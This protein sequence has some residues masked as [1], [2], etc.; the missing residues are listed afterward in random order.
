MGE[1]KT[2]HLC[3][4]IV[5]LRSICPASLFSRSLL[6]VGAHVRAYTRFRM[7]LARFYS[8]TKVSAFV[9]ARITYHCLPVGKYYSNRMPRGVTIMFSFA[10]N[11]IARPHRFERVG[12]SKEL[13]ECE[14]RDE[15]DVWKFAV[16]DFVGRRKGLFVPFKRMNMKRNFISNARYKW[17]V[18]SEIV[19]PSIV[20]KKTIISYRLK[21]K[22]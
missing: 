21:K 18:S 6:V 17:L 1:P 8:T 7:T 3:I 4:V 11:P 9:P 12:A 20:V 13:Q 2:G 19:Y 22:E 14:K 16:D 10:T 5:T 15:R